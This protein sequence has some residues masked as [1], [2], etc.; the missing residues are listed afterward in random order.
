L[1]NIRL[2]FIF[3]AVGSLAVV[4]LAA[5]QWSIIDRIT[6]FLYVP[7][8]GVV[9]LGFAAAGVG[10][11]T[12]IAKAKHIGILA[13]APASMQVVAVALVL[14]VP[15]TN[16]WLETDFALY[17][18]QREDAVRRVQNGELRPNV[19]HNPSLIKLGRD[20]S[21]ISMGGNE[22]VVEEHQGMKYVF[23]FTYRGI[24]DSYSGFLYVPS[25]GDPTKYSDLSDGEARQVR[26]LKRNWFY[27][28]H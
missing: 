10:S 8:L 27:V 17:R 4:V 6:P 1:R 3:S 7:L 25:G 2:R 16:L 23:F 28:S 15:F 20:F 21:L 22:I 24:L 14:F 12:S 11:L 19:S 26:S 9:W 5:F 18:G 13:F